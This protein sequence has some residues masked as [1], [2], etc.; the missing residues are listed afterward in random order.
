M[1]LT[2]N[3]RNTLIHTIDTTTM[4]QVLKSPKYCP[5][6]IRTLNGFCS[7]FQKRKKKL[8]TC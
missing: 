5:R 3:L 6:Y 1:N 8:T 4:N 7:V 2:N